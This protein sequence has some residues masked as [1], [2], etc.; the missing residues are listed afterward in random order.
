MMATWTLHK[1]SMLERSM[2]RYYKNKGSLHAVADK[3]LWTKAPFKWASILDIIFD[4][5][6]V[7]KFLYIGVV[8]QVFSWKSLQFLAF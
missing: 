8:M 6:L 7:S 5:I 2:G 3:E 4:C 1:I